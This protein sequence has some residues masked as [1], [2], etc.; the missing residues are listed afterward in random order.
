MANENITITETGSDGTEK[1][2]EIT[3]AKVDD[4]AGDDQAFAAE[5][6]EAMFD[7]GSGSDQDVAYMDYD[8]DGTLDTAGADTDGDGQVDT[9][10]ADTDGDGQIDAAGR[11]L[12]GDGNL[13]VAV[14]DTDGDG[15]V[16]AIL[17]D[18]D[19]DGQMDVADIDGDGVV[20]FTL[21]ADQGLPTEEEISTDSIEFTVGE[22][23]FPVAEPAETVTE[24]EDAT[25]ETPADLDAAPMI[26]S[27]AADPTFDEDYSASPDGAA[28]AAAETAEVEAAEADAQQAHAD[29]ARDAQAAADEFIGKGDYAAA[30]EAREVAEN[31]SWEAGDNSMLGS[32]DSSDLEGAA[33]KQE[34]AEDYSRQQQEH[35]EEGDYAAAK[36]DAINA[37]YATGDADYLAGGADHTGQSDN[38][39]YNL[40]WAVHQEGNAEYYAEN[41]EKYAEAGDFDNAERYAEQAEVYQGSADDFASRADEESYN[42]DDDPSSMVETGG[43]YDAGSYDAG[44]FDAGSFDAAGYDASVGGV[45]AGIDTSVDTSAVSSYDTTSDV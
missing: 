43:S 6:V 30:A 26:E 36:E 14:F 39:A 31:E 25:T 21:E 35:I 33:W 20:D 41:A 8:G 22:D 19:G 23:G 16:D 13:D 28:T 18:T 3:T 2:F 29:A 24:F 1:E 27:P 12:D 11:D 37:G 32:S 17:A 15:E 5:A 9:V 7:D 42:Y 10:V 34:I 40:D 44:G 38:D 45:D 4:L